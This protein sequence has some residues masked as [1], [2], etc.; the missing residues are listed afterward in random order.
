MDVA[1]AEYE[2]QRN[3]A[4]LPIFGLTCQFAALQPPSPEQELL[5]AALLH[6][7]EETNRF[8]GTLAGTV[9]IPEFFS[10]ENLGRIIGAAGAAPVA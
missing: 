8:I 2:S 5:F 3:Q 10:P 1:L 6:N 7:Q 9:P 4:A